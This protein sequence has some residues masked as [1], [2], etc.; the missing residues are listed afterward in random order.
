MGIL[1]IVA[2][3]RSKNKAL[4]TMIVACV[5]VVIAVTA[6]VGY[7][8]RMSTIETYQSDG[9]AAT[10]LRI[11]KW[12]MGFAATHPLG[13]GFF[14]YTTSVIEVPQTEND[15]AHVEIGRAYH[16]SY[17]EVLGE[18]GIPGL[19]MFLG[20]ALLAFRRLG[21]MRKM[22]RNVPEFEWVAS[23]CSAIEV[24]LAV[25]FTSG[26]FVSLSFQPMFWYFIAMTLALNG[27]MYHAMRA[28]APAERPWAR[29]QSLA[30][31][32]PSPILNGWRSRGST[33]ASRMG[34]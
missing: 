6:G 22:T 18:E 13:G 31:A 32:E 27:Y 29:G 15:P 16:S 7:K 19:A 26:A 5:A 12:T 14:A 20:L 8:Q 4:Y 1:G 23:L 17:F 24:G 33:A 21:R 9:S 11:W 34:R 10:R 30:A 28:A 3:A 2:I 25:F